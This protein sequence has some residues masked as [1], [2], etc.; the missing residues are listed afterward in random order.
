MSQTNVELA[1]APPL[2]TEEENRRI[3]IVDD[4]AAIH[5]D[6][7]KIL[8]SQPE[9][10]DSF[11]DLERGLFGDMMGSEFSRGPDPAY[12]DLTHAYQG[13]EAFKMVEQA[14]EEGRPFA[15]VFMDVRMPPGWDGIETIKRIWERW[16]HLEMVICTAYSDY[17]WE[18]ILQKVGTTDQLMF[19]RKPFDV[20][21]VKQMALALVKKWN[22]GRKARQYVSDLEKAVADRTRE[23]KH[24]VAEHEKAMEEIRI[25]QGII[26]MCMYCNKVRNDEN[27]WQRVDHYIQSHT[28]ANISHSV[29]PECYES[30]MSSMLKEIEEED[31]L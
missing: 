11:D 18:K 5:E 29:C 27:F 14:E 6:F 30:A 1:K 23:L 19:L 8:P 26:P 15:L 10:V 7:Q 9:E 3:L 2:E 25:L 20:I 16:N 31:E 4:N 12:Y 28:V 22:L 24:K 21:S 17:S 13:E